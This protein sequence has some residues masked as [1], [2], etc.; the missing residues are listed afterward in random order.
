MDNHDHEHDEHGL[1]A[2]I[3]PIS[4]VDILIA[5]LCMVMIIHFVIYL[6]NEQRTLPD[7]ITF[8]T[9]LFYFISILIILI[10][11]ILHFIE[12]SEVQS[13]EASFH[14]ELGIVQWF[15]FFISRALLQFSFLC[16]LFAVFHGSTLKYN[17]NVFLMVGLYISGLLVFGIVIV[18]QMAVMHS[19]DPTETNMQFAL[20]YT[21][22]DVML[23]GI[24]VYLFVRKLYNLLL[25]MNSVGGGGGGS[26]T[27]ESANS[28][29]NFPIFIE[30]NKL[31][32][33]AMAKYS[34]ITT[35][36]GMSLII[37]FVCLFIV[38]THYAHANEVNI[39]YLQ[40]C[41]STISIMIDLFCVYLSCKLSKRIYDVL[42]KYPHQ[43]CCLLLCQQIVCVRLENDSA[44]DI[45]KTNS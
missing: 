21:A 32:L 8:V 25:M 35:T 24:L 31:F 16:K 43:K 4:I 17:K 23:I 7:I 11:D 41:I 5:I 27:S 29:G 20:I 28:P 37:Q 1:E 42:C 14:L 40:H 10:H 26:P 36:I 6:K 3:L 30:E 33:G 45:S 39:E 22:F 12:D 38:S 34:L 19:V 44:V 15:V 9:I 13:I 18:I 2:D